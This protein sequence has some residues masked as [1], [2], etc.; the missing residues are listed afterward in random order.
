M[1]AMYLDSRHRLI[2][3]SEVYRGT[4]SRAATE[5]R[6]VLK[7]GLLRGACSLVLFHTHPSRDP[8]PSLEDLAFT[9]RMAEAGDA[10]G[11]R[12]LDHLILGGTRRWVS[13]KDR[14]A[15]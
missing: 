2:A 4:L 6:E 1:G 14:G 11:I 7:E 15:W 5:P 3:I 9:R 8:S 13:L 12:L 10:V